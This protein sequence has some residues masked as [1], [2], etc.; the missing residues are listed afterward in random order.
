MSIEDL[1][2]G[3]KGGKK[4]KAKAKPGKEDL[5][6]KG[7]GGKG[8]KD[9]AKKAKNTERA[10]RGDGK[11]FISAEDKAKLASAI[12]KKLKGKESN[13]DFAK[14]FNIPTWKVRKAAKF[15]AAEKK[16]KYADGVMQA[17]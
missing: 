12:L 16:I 1:L 8:K 9:A 4:A 17:K 5:I 13:R 14:R 15:L 3:K 10:D 7:K 11:F 2:G 6:G